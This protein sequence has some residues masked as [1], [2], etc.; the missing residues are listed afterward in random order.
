MKPY[1]E[2]WRAEGS[3]LLA[4]P[5]D[6]GERGIAEF[7]YRD[8]TN[9]RYSRA[10]FASHAPAMYRALAQVLAIADD[11]EKGC[12]NP[13]DVYEAIAGVARATK[14]VVDSGMNNVAEAHHA[15][16]SG[17]QELAPGETANVAAK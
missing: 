8:E 11:A 6:G 5:V 3:V 4:T 13:A 15:K 17:I 16:Q 12:V 7:T 1:E 2:T 14:E 9:G 10:E